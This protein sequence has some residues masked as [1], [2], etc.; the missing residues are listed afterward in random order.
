MNLHL[1]DNVSASQRRRREALSLY[2]YL[3][4]LDADELSGIVRDK[5]NRPLLMR[6]VALRCLIWL[7]PQGRMAHCTFPVRRRL[8]RWYFDV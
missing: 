7:V 2:R 3:Q 6:C 5:A 4:H 1:T 8:T